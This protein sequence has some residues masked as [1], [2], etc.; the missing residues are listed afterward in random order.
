MWIQGSH[1]PPLTPK[2]LPDQ[3]H[4]VQDAGQAGPSQCHSPSYGRPD[5]T[6]AKHCPLDA[7]N[8]EM[9]PRFCSKNVFSFL[10]ADCTTPLQ[11]GQLISARSPAHECPHLHILHLTTHPHGPFSHCH[12]FFCSHGFAAL[13]KH[14]WSGVTPK[15]AAAPHEQG[16]HVPTLSALACAH[17]QR[18]ARAQQWCLEG[19]AD[20]RTLRWCHGQGFQ[21]HL[22][23]STICCK[24][25]IGCTKPEPP[26]VP[27][28]EGGGGDSEEIG[29]LANAPTLRPRT[30]PPT[31]RSSRSNG[32]PLSPHDQHILRLRGQE[33]L[34][35]TNGQIQLF[36]PKV[37]D[38]HLGHCWTQAGLCRGTLASPTMSQ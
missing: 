13:R 19:I 34:G 11:L 27:P 30:Y 26:N 15:S 29:L 5:I 3:S 36:P 7:G 16:P 17:G 2:P 35:S 24:A 23:R 12:S 4:M 37:P 20:A 22:Q 25:P 31:G 38:D 1:Q 28:R 33:D 18:C 8:E 14:A 32:L 9:E 10:S 6:M 21:K